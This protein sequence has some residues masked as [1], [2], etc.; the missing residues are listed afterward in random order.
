MNLIVNT[1]LNYL[2]VIGGYIILLYMVLFFAAGSLPQYFNFSTVDTVEIVENTESE[3]K[4]EQK[5]SKEKNKDDYYRGHVLYSF[6]QLE[7]QVTSIENLRIWYKPVM[8]NF[9]PPPE[10]A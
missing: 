10:Q 7:Q 3:T 5:D 2:K 4:S 1:I 9:T 6:T 8:E